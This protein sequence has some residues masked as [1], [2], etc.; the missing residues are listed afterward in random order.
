MDILKFLNRTNRSQS[1]LARELG[2]DASS[3]NNWIR[4]KNT[5]KYELCLRLLDMGIGI[6]ELFSADAWEKIKADH[7]AEFKDEVRLTPEE[8]AEIVR[9]GLDALRAA[10]T[11]QAP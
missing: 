8:C 1:D 4:G 7:A 3:V 11:R 6:D 2:V 10:R 9:S 5:P